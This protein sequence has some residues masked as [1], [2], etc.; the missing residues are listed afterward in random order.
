MFE[1]VCFYFL[2]FLTYSFLGW[3]MEVCVTFYDE[4]KFIN[5]G[6]LIGPCCSIYGWGCM[7]LLFLLESSKNDFVGLFL[8]AIVICSILEYMTSLVMEK[9]FRARWWDYSD[10]K[11]NLNG[12]IC[13]ETMIPFGILACLVLYFI[14]PNLEYYYGL[15]PSGILIFISIILFMIYLIDNFVSFNIVFHIASKINH[16]E[17][18]DSTEEISKLVKEKIK[19]APYLYRRLLGAFPHFQIVLHKV[20]R[21]VNEIGKKMKNRG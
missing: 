20:E 6:F 4:H 18:K 16:L 12:R 13:L 2:C 19:K 8:K 14:Q 9:L 1:T 7:L 17:L 5:R 15:I 11:F 21:K 10:K 3:I